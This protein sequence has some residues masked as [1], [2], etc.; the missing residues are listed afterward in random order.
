MQAAMP[1]VNLNPP[2][3]RKMNLDESEELPW[4][5]SWEEIKSEV[6]KW[7]LTLGYLPKPKEVIEFMEERYLAPFKRGERD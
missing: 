1:M 7:Y 2:T 5:T 3:K 6:T 4:P